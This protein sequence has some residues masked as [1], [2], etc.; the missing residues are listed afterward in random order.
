MKKIQKSIPFL[1]VTAMVLSTVLVSGTALAEESTPADTTAAGGVVVE[2]NADSQTGYT[3]SFT[4]YDED[5]TNVQIMGGFQFYKENDE[6]VY[7]IGYNLEEGD[8]YENYLINAE[9]WSKD[10][11]LWH[12]NDTGYVADMEYDSETGAW[13]YSLDL[14]GGSY[15]YQ[16]NVSTDNGETYE[17]VIDPENIPYCNSLG[18]HQT[19]SQFY[20]PYDPEK[21]SENDDWSWLLPAENE[22]DRGTLIQENYPSAT[23]EEAPI[24]LYLPAG[25]DE[26]REEPYK[27]L[28]LSHGAGGDEADWFYQG[29][30]GNIVDRLT[31]AGEC[32]PFIMVAM[33]N[34][35]FDWDFDVII[36]NVKNYLIP[37][38]EE[39]YNV[40]TEPEDR[41]F[42]GL[43]MGAMTTNKLLFDDPEYFGYYGLFS[44]SRV[45]EFPE[46]DDYSAYHNT[47]LY[48]A[49]GW[50]DH[51]IINKS[52]SFAYHG[53]TDMTTMGLAEKLDELGIPYNNGNDIVIVQGGHD[54]FTW[55]QILRDF[56]STTLWK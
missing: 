17:A 1:P 29:N 26:N 20:V 11:D 16:Y 38:V 10:Q 36:D 24:E 56:V 45:Y 3:V 49:A 5:A 41:A 25:Y 48:L 34:T 14:P 12:V 32:E 18:A 13:T 52:L 9:D 37:F 2:E 8:S 22:E 15:L 28:Y 40:S 7:G 46:L 31:A 30:A 23:G 47:N 53:D 55:P 21:Q 51:A 42:G 54:W 35:I 19:R 39:N 27:V 6:H 4:Y 50:E 33:N 44:G 43:S